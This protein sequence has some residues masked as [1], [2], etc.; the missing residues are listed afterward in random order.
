MPAAGPQRLDEG[1]AGGAGDTGADLADAG[2]L[3]QDA[4]VHDGRDAE[5]QHLAQVDA[6]RGRGEIHGAGREG[7]VV[8]GAYALHGRHGPAGVL[9]GAPHEGA[10]ARGAAD[11]HAAQAHGLDDGAVADV[12]GRVLGAGAGIVEGLVQGRRGREDP[13]GEAA[14][15]QGEVDAVAAHGGDDGGVLHAV[16]GVGRA[17]ARREGQAQEGVVVA[18]DELDD[19]PQGLPVRAALQQQRHEVAQPQQGAGGAAGVHLVA[20][21][22]ALGDGL[23]D[24][25]TLAAGADGLAHG[26]TED[27]AHPAQALDGAPVVGAHPDDVALALVEG[28]PA[29]VAEGRVL[30]DDDLHG[31]R[32]DAAH[33][34]YAAEAVVVGEH[35]VPAL[36]LRLEPGAVGDPALEDGGGLHGALLRVA[37]VVE[38]D[39]RAGM[40]DVVGLHAGNGLDGGLHVDPQGTALLHAAHRLRVGRLDLG[41]LKA[42]EDVD[43]PAVAAGGGMP[44]HLHGRDALLLQFFVESFQA[45]IDD[46]YA[47]IDAGHG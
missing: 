39:G 38:V 30:G 34:P 26:R 42:A 23:E 4:G 22:D 12:A 11:D 3:V 5:A 24:V 45:E 19:V 16:G 44:V 13:V 28:A 20:H 15:A 1:L 18:A 47:L 6:E 32:D 17:L 14:D 41:R 31:R 43:E 37:H 2:R 35:D 27:V 40:Q 25:Q 29:A 7:G 10:D 46:P 36:Q 9:H 21:E 8:R 33:G